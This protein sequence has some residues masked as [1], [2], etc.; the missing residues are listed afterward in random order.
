MATSNLDLSFIALL[1][2]AVGRAVEMGLPT[3]REDSQFHRLEEG[4]SSDFAESVLKRVHR[5]E[6]EIGDAPPIRAFLEDG[7]AVARVVNAAI[8]HHVKVFHSKKELTLPALGSSEW[9][10]LYRN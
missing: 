7:R 9:T 4:L 2:R 3:H 1:S 10:D 6:P 5:P 8:S